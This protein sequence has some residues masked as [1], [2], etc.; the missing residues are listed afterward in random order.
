MRGKV[1]HF[2][3]NSEEDIKD[4]PQNFINDYSCSF[5]RKFEQKN[6]CYESNVGNTERKYVNQI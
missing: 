6:P 2:Y 5:K 4:S 3:F 1:L